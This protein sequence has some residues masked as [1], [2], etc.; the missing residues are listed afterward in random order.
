[1]NARMN[2]EIAT[3]IGYAT[4]HGETS[5]TR[6]VIEDLS[7]MLQAA[8]D[9]MTPEQRIAFQEDANVLGIIEAAGGSAVGAAG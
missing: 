7:T 9:L 2:A 3:L 8:W 6:Q 5:D 4:A 1:M